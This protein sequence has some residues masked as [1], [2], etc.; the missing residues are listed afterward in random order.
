MFL[1][2]FSNSLIIMFIVQIYKNILNV[3]RENKLVCSIL[4]RSFMSIVFFVGENW[5]FT[6][7][8]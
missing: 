6:L 2:D 3:V 4:D 5:W 8:Y 1:K 7:S